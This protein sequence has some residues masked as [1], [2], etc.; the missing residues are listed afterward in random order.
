MVAPGYLARGMVDGSMRTAHSL[1]RLLA[2][3]VDLT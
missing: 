1:L 3:L 2:L